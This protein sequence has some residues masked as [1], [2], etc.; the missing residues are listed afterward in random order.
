MWSELRVPC[1]ERT[2]RL[3]IHYA[4]VQGADTQRW[5]RRARVWQSTA[6]AVSALADW[7]RFL[8]WL[9]RVCCQLEEYC[10]FS[11]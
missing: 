1:Y 7:V 10:T 4:A 5:A 11:V 6:Q 8:L 3:G 2:V 9:V